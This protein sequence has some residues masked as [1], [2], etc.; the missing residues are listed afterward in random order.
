MNQRYLKVL[1]LFSVSTLI[2][3]LIFNSK[4]LNNS[5]VKYVLRTAL[6]YGIFASGLH[7]LS[8]FKRG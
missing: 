2:P 3:T 6:G 5:V 7:Y 8:K 4:C 1:A